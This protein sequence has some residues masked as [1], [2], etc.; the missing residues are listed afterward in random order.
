MPTLPGTVSGVPHGDG[1]LPDLALARA[2]TDRRADLRAQPGLLTGLLA[3]PRTRVLAL[4]TRGKAVTERPHDP[5]APAERV[6]LAL[7]APEPA[8]TTR[9]AVFLGADPPTPDDPARHTA[10]VAV[11]D[12]DARGE[13][14]RSLRSV[15]VALDDRDAGLFTTALALANW[16]ATHTHCP[17]CGARTEPELAGWTRRCPR[18]D[19]EHYPRTD[20]AVIM[21]VTD[22]DDRLLLA[23][24]SGFTTTGVSV[25][26]GFVEPGE[27]MAAAVAREVHEEV[28]L[29][30]GE[31]A[32]LGDQPWPFPASLMVGF[33]ARS[34]GTDL[35][36]QD[37]E[38]EL[39]RW[40]T[41]AELAD[42]VAREQVHIAGRLSIA[43]R[44]I[45]HWYGEPIDAPEAR[46]RRR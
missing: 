27:T 41:R 38:I 8:D 32:Y 7:R 17:R 46:V 11:V 19:S 45:E 42:A 15:G 29:E 6:G 3:D 31:V 18:D 43:R 22:P 12:T 5:T 37:G 13:G 44:L 30:V 26:A 40:W 1:F 2:T 9:L 39:A 33:M 21:A 23:R 34:T 10:Y 25:L 16:H 4:N 20:P 14:W 35:T 28:G 36:L 24:G